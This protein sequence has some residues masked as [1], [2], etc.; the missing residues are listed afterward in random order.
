MGL[1]DAI[2]ISIFIQHFEN[3]FHIIDT[4]ITKKNFHDPTAWEP[5]SVV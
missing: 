4:K 5:A 3:Q 2:L 1:I